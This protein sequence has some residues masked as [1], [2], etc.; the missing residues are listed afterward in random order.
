M[1]KFVKAVVWFNGIVSSLGL[2]G[3]VAEPQDENT[4][5]GVLLSLVMIGFTAWGIGVLAATKPKQE[6]NT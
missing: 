3:F 1:R 4:V 5:F 6:T 2:L